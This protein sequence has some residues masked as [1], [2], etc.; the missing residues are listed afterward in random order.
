MKDASVA[1]RYDI[2]C[3]LG[4]SQDPYCIKKTIKRA[5]NEESIS[6]NEMFL[7]VQALATHA[8]GVNSLA[9][10]VISGGWI[11]NQLLTK[12]KMT[13]ICRLVSTAFTKREQSS[14]ALEMWEK[15][16]DPAVSYCQ[17]QR[18]KEANNFRSWELKSNGVS[19]SSR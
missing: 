11:Q 3:S 17:T 16:A 1:E 8:Q 18:Q 4:Y 9:K 6:R 12:E 2:L 15:M 13:S 14:T 10:F 5:V 19:T 7:T